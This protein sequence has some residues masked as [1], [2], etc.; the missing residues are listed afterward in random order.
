MRFAALCGQGRDGPE[1]A[2]QWRQRCSCT[3]LPARVTQPAGLFNQAEQ[4]CP[5]ELAGLLQSS[6]SLTPSPSLLEWRQ[7]GVSAGL[8][9]GTVAMKCQRKC[10]NAATL[11]ITEI[12]SENHVE[13]LHLCEDCARKYLDDLQ[14][15]PAPV[16]ADD[17]DQPGVLN[18]ECEI[19]GTKFVDI[20]KTGRLGCPHDYEVFRDELVPLLESIHGETRHCGKSPRRLPQ[21]KQTQAELTQ[22]RKQLQQA[23]NK[24]AYEEAARLRDRIRQLEEN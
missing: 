16:A 14:A 21:N 22:L 7:V 19:C 12:G 5:E 9:V 4:G 20:R 6:L 11:H 3:A 10:P 17:S 24:E 23:I 15:K 2:G 8:E 18:R 1:Q 13:E